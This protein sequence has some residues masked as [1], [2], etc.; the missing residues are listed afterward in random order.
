MGPLIVHLCPY[1]TPSPPSMH[2]TPRCTSTTRPPPQP[3]HDRTAPITTEHTPIG[4][5]RSP[6]PRQ[7]DTTLK[8]NPAPLIAHANLCQPLATY[9]ISIALAATTR[10]MPKHSVPPRDRGER[11]LW[12]VSGLTIAP[13]VLVWDDQSLDHHSH[14]QNMKC[15]GTT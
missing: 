5:C 7:T 13:L 9:F 12:T 3:T 2:R 4:C 15:L 14:R 8:S 1:H 10:P 6:C 11:Q